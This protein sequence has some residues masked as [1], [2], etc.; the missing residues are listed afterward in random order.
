MRA[1]RGLRRRRRTSAER[2]SARL[3]LIYDF[4]SNRCIKAERGVLPDELG[5]NVEVA[6]LVERRC[7]ARPLQCPAGASEVGFQ[8]RSRSRRQPVPLLRQRGH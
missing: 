6:C 1:R 4:K 2:A 7:E 3:C 5:R 8:S